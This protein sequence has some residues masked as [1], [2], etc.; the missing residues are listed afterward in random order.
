MS[1]TRLVILDRDGVINRDRRDYVKTPDEWIPLP[2][3]V[4]AIVKLSLS[5]FTIAVATNQS[6]I[7]RGFYSLDTLSDMH[8]KMIQLVEQEGGAISDIRYCPHRPDEQC[9]CRKPLPAMLQQ[10][11]QHFEVED[12]SQVWMVGDSLRDLQAGEAAGTKLALVLTGNGKST[13]RQLEIPGA[14]DGVE[15][16]SSLKAFADHMSR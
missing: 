7:G 14:P 13:Q 2:G 12:P 4:E 10:I 16:F 9:N 3:A 6:G 8:D 1:R 11:M 15:I 5:G